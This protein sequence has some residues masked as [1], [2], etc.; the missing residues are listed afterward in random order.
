MRNSKQT[1]FFSGHS[2]ESSATRST[3]IVSLNIKYLFCSVVFCL[4]LI[5]A[6]HAQTPIKVDVLYPQQLEQSQ[7]IRLPGTVLARQHAQL[8]SLES[9]RVA[10]LAVEVGDA[11][12]QGQ[13]L[14]SLEDRLA[15]LTVA[16]AAAEVKAAELNLQEAKRLYDEVRRLSVQQVVAKT[17]I[18]ERAALLA[19]A[20][21]ELARV[22][23]NHSLQQERLKRHSLR[24]PFAGVIAVRNVDVGEWVTPQTAVLTLVAQND[25]RLSVAVPQQHHS[26]LHDT[27]QVEVMVVPDI[28]GIEPVA[29]TLSRMVPVTDVQTRTFTAQIDLPDSAN[30]GLLVGMSAQAVLTVP[31]TA[32]AAIVLPRS[33]V[34]QHPDGNSS[35]FVV[36]NNRAQR[37]VTPVTS[38]PGDQVAVYGQAADQAYIISGVELLTEGAPVQINVV[39]GN[40]R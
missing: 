39:Q 3:A 24:A 31:D 36:V 30:S 27:D 21:V 15:E 35:L 25:L 1:I 5:P 20:E 13:V 23:A 19:N 12:S 2:A 40:K 37:V 17:L 33:A 9:G 4:M 26:L 34:K 29:A 7:T 32:Q 22:K 10:S 11:V 8:A 14:L 6:A 18:A 16:G 38:L 28:A